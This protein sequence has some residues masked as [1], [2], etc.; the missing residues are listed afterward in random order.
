MKDELKELLKNKL[1]KDILT[2]FYQN[3]ASIDTVGGV[4]AWVHSDR[5]RVKNALDKLVRLGVLEKD[6]M[7]STNGY[8][9]THNEKIMHVVK[10]LMR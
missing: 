2:F 10:E 6:S 3:Q 9:Y 5:K 8:C 4:S 1:V 7:G